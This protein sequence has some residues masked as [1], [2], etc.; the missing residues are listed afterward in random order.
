MDMM[1]GRAKESHMAEPGDTTRA[2][3]K[4]RAGI[5]NL[6]HLT[7]AELTDVI[8]KA[9]ALRQEKQE[10]AKAALLMK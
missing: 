9:E 6:D 8:R 3:G 4:G 1:A 10:E 5:P 2:S 7:V